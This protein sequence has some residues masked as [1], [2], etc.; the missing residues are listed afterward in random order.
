MNEWFYKATNKKLDHHGTL[1]LS[2]RGFLCR[3]A[4]TKNKTW[5]ANVQSVLFGDVMNFYFIGKKALP[6][7]A[8]EIIRREDYKIDKPEPTADDFTGPVVGCALYEVVDPSFIEA[9]DPDGAYEPDPKL[10][11]LTGWLLRKIGPAATAPPK[12]LAEMPTLVKR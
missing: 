2:N 4:Y 7:G 1:M 11:K 12:F 6:I 10:E 5:V 9:F 3:S 8:F